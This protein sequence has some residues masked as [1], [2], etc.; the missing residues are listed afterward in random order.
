MKLSFYSNLIFSVVII[1]ERMYMIIIVVFGSAFEQRL[2]RQRKS[3]YRFMFLNL[4][5]P[6]ESFWCHFRSYAMSF[7]HM[8]YAS[9]SLLWHLDFYNCGGAWVNLRCES[10]ETL[11]LD[12]SVFRGSC[13]WYKWKFHISSSFISI[14]HSSSVEKKTFTHFSIGETPRILW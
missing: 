3:H 10:S 6:N 2:L 7:F 1:E 5:V 9:E 4:F 13:Y 14:S 8:N 12:I 11:R